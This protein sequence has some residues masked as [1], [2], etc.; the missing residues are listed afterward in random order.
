MG[1]PRGPLGSSW[2]PG[3]PHFFFFTLLHPPS[4]IQKTFSVPRG[5]STPPSGS[6][7]QLQLDFIQL[8]LRMGYQYVLLV[9]MFSGW[10]KAF[11]CHKTDALTMAKKWLEIVFPIGGLPS[12]LQWSGHPLHWANCTSLNKNLSDFL[13]LSL[14]LSDT[15][16]RQSQEN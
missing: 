6:F 11:P 12:S 9:C 2:F 8:L 13:E 1:N 5:L 4:C 16:I 15:I 3:K 10:A 7:T 14:S